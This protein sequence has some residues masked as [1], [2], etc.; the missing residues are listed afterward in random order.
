MLAELS[1]KVEAGPE[2]F[3]GLFGD[4][5]AL[6]NCAPGLCLRRVE[7][8]TSSDCSGDLLFTI[9]VFSDLCFALLFI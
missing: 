4:S 3:R 8:V 6:R 7:K 2:G 5:Q 1:R 9:S